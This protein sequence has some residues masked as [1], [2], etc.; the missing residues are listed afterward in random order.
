MTSWAGNR[1]FPSV[2]KTMEAVEYFE[3]TQ[4]GFCSNMNMLFYCYLRALKNTDSLYVHDFPNCISDIFPLFQ[5]ILKTNSTV[6]YLREIPKDSKKITNKD[7]LAPNLVNMPFSRLKS[8]ARDLFSYN[9]DTQGKI[10]DRIRGRGL[11]RTVFDV[12]VH[13]RSGDKITTGEMKR[14]SV[15]DYVN[16]L[17]VFQQRI[18]KPTLKIFVMTDNISMYD[19]LQKASPPTWSFTSLAEPGFYNQNGHLQ[20]L[21]N[22]LTP[23]KKL[24]LFYQFLTELHI[25]QNIPNLVVTFSSHIGRF[26]YLT[27]RLV[28]TKDN[29]LSLDM[30][31]WSPY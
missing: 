22:S 31:E 2:K 16:A 11:E 29:I 9:S 21:F 30:P 24:D 6:K 27:S 4:G 23:E 12:G 19:Q 3:P 5:S 10:S 1:G 13:I 28:T 14:L 8:I 15:S 17:S 26:L 20:D 25:M 18:G 7:V